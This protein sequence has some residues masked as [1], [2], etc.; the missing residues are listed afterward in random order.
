MASELNGFGTCLSVQSE[1]LEVSG[2]SNAFL[3]A[4]YQVHIQYAQFLLVWAMG[5]LQVLQAAPE[6]TEAKKWAIGIM[7]KTIVTQHDVEPSDEMLAQFYRVL[8]QSLVVK[9]KVSMQIRPLT[10]LEF[11]LHSPILFSFWET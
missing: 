10:K 1:V 11:L 4:L 3:E 6:F 8:H 5:S 9:E 7:Q 2:D